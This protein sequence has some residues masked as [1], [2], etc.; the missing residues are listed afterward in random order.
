MKKESEGERIGPLTPPSQRFKKPQG[1]SKQPPIS[2]S[3]P[4]SGKN[5]AQCSFHG[6]GIPASAGEGHIQRS[7][8]NRKIPRTN[9]GAKRKG[10]F[11]TGGLGFFRGPTGQQGLNPLEK[12]RPK[13]G[14]EP[15]KKR[16]AAQMMPHQD[17]IG[18]YRTHPQKRKKNP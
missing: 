3:V 11:V 18:K 15:A 1:Q 10:E 12:K 8:E 7:P 4:P 14:R 5:C 13:G 6:G 2:Q 9:V 16:I 17:K